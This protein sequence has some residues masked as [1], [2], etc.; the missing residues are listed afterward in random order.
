MGWAMTEI[1]GKAS[2]R[3]L[4]ARVLAKDDRQAFATLVRRHQQ[5]VRLLL[6]R[7]C[8][9]D[10]ALADDL[11]QDTFL[12]AWRKLSAYRA[13]AALGTW[14]YRI[15][16]NRFLMYQRRWHPTVVDPQRLLQEGGATFTT[17]T[18]DTAESG[19]AMPHDVRE[20]LARLPE[21]E[22][23]AIVHCYYLQLS[24]AEAAAAMDCPVGT[25]K[26]HVFR[27]RRK[28]RS[29]LQDWAPVEGKNQ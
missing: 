7:L 28:L 27:A 17:V 22:R 4:V 25:L 5:P 3:V 26:S 14:L 2:D 1:L 9:D 29:W 20:A 24:H 10:A 15:A 13:E 19:L 23:A 8:G 18:M 12:Q 21:V 11:A 6:R 16:Y